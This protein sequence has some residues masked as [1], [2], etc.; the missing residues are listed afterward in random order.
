MNHELQFQ[1]IRYA[2]IT[3]TNYRLNRHQ[4]AKTSELISYSGLN[5]FQR[6]NAN[7]TFPRKSNVSSKAD[8]IAYAYPGQGRLEKVQGF[9]FGEWG[10]LPCHQ[11]QGEQNYGHVLYCRRR[12][13]FRSQR[14]VGPGPLLRTY[15]LS[16]FRKISRG[17]RVQTIPFLPRR[18]FERFDVDARDQLQVR[19]S[20]GS[21]R[22]SGG[23]F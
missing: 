2:E 7:K 11:R 22:V 4:N 19:S 20:C 18:T 6:P 16:G 21:C 17:N 23:H 1:P 8:T 12:G 15:V 10:D 13:V 3:R 5:T 14:N 9:S